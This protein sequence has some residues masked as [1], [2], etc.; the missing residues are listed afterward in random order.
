MTLILPPDDHE[1]AGAGER[2][3]KNPYMVMVQ[4]VHIQ[5]LPETPTPEV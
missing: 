5:N 4:P 3:P 1:F 2:V